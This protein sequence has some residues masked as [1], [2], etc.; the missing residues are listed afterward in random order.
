[1][2]TDNEARDYH[3]RW[4]AGADGGGVPGETRNVAF[5]GTTQAFEKFKPGDPAEFMLDRALGP[6]FAK[7]PEI[8]NSFTLDRINGRDVGAKEGGRIIPVVLSPDE[9]FITADQPRYDWAKDKEVAPDKEWSV[10]ATDQNVIEKMVATEGFKKD[11]AI[12]ERYLEQARAIPADKAPGIA[13]DL[14]EG[15][16]VNLDGMDQD[17]NR[18]VNNYGGRPYNDADRAEVIKLAKQSW[19]ANGYEGIKYINTSPMENATAKNPT[20]YI[21]FDPDKTVSPL[22]GDQHHPETQKYLDQYDSTEPTNYHP[23]ETPKDTP[24]SAVAH[25]QQI[26]GSYKPLEGL[27][28]PVMNLKDGHYQP[29]PVASLKDAAA[30][31]M[32]KAGMTYEPIQKY[33][34]ADPVQGAKIAQAFEQM[35]HDPDN[36]AVKASYDALAK[37]TM[38]QWQA[39]KDTGLKVDWIKPGQA[40]P[41]ADTPRSAERDVTV[42]NHWW[43]FP[44]D[45]GFGSDPNL[46]GNPLL[47]DSG[48]VIGGRHA[49]VN[50]VFRVVHDIFGHIKDGNGFTPSGEDNAWRGHYAM[51]SPLARAALTTETRGQTNWVNFGPHGIDNRAKLYGSGAV[52]SNTGG[53]GVIYAPQKIGLLPQWAQD[54]AKDRP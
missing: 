42:N 54:G 48:E 6:H 15:K 37:E 30:A 12:L 10:R 25:A 21:V 49:S 24:E 2:T 19:M 39:I 46:K 52:S 34:P 5:H 29:G 17:L 1:M 16:K 40:D 18:F 3:G 20:S 50:D 27:P 4:T 7:D 23:S 35:K 26:A 14:V 45:E 44:T 28:Q 13:R 47:K 9:K 43:G 31:Y 32:K 33:Q 41:Y 11:P 53:S 36:P 22:Y 38:A 51:F 8:A